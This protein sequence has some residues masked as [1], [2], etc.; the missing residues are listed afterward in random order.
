MNVHPTAVVEDGARIGADVRIGP[1]CVIGPEVR[2]GDGCILHS[3]VC[4]E[5]DTHL[6][7]ENE[8]WPFVNLGSVAQDR[9]FDPSG[10]RGIVR[11]GAR[12]LL[13]E[14]VTINP[15]T[16]RGGGK[17]IMGDDNMLQ[18]GAHLGHDTMIGVRTPP[19]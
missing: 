4:I 1:F 12:N 2:I 18:I 5:G 15:G 19:S 3:H 7:P 16:Q 9:K 8:I 17:T 10:P 6:G 11:I 13:R 14:Y